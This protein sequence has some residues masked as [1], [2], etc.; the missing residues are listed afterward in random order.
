MAQ[1]KKRLKSM[2]W[3]GERTFDALHAIKDGV[4]STVMPT[5]MFPELGI[6]YVGPINGHDIDALVRALSYARDYDGP[7]PSPCGR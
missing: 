5:E 2:G 1:D 6:K 4:T 7:S 3:V